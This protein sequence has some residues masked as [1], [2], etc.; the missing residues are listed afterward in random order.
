MGESFAELFE[1]SA[2]NINTQPGSIIDGT[3]VDISNR[4][5]PET[6]RELYIEGHYMTAREVNGTVR[7]VNHGWMNIPGIQTWLEYSSEYW[8]LDWKDPLREV[9]REQAAWQAMQ[10]NEQ[11]Q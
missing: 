4:S 8:Q 2:N 11:T 10:K 6:V 7:M 9:L 3:V 5:A 1:E